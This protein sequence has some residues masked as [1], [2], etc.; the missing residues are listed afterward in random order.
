MAM[1]RI[2]MAEGYNSKYGNIY[3]HLNQDGENKSSHPSCCYRSPKHKVNEDADIKCQ[4]WL[5]RY[6]I[7]F[8]VI[9]NKLTWPKCILQE[10]FLPVKQTCEKSSSLAGIYHY[11]QLFKSMFLLHLL[12]CICYV[13][14]L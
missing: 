6:S 2:N 4:V 10:V 3:S 5:W 14:A 11:Q 13:M 7:K 8:I 9:R 1:V 12:Q